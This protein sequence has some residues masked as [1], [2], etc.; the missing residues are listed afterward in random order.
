MNARQP[1]EPIELSEAAVDA[2]FAYV[3]DL[4]TENAR[5]RRERKPVPKRI[6]ADVNPL[7]QWLTEMLFLTHAPEDGPERAWPVILELIARAPD[8]EGLAF[9]GA[10]ALEDLVN[11][12]GSRFADRIEAASD[13]DTRFTLAL[14]FVWPDTEVSDRVRALIMRARQAAGQVTF[15]NTRRRGS[16]VVGG[17]Q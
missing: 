6:P 15:P 4:R 8:N 1:A 5:L 11:R 9:V 7:S 13:S 14:A 12:A 16:H 10:S 17:P 3:H 2:Y